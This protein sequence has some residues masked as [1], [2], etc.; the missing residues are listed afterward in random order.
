MDKIQNISTKSMVIAGAVTGVL[1]ALTYYSW[2]PT[3]KPLVVLE[4]KNFDD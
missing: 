1:A 3:V 4:D 2:V